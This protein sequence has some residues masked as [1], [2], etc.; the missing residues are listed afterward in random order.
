MKYVQWYHRIKPNLLSILTE[1]KKNSSGIKQMCFKACIELFP[2]D[3]TYILSLDWIFNWGYIKIKSKSGVTN[4]ERLRKQ[5][6]A[7]NVDTGISFSN[8]KIWDVR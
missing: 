1:R 8:F 3:I 7:D 6:M 5:E 4:E 2:N